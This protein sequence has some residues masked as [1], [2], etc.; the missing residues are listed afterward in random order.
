MKRLSTLGSFASVLCLAGS[1]ALAVP[2]TEAATVGTPTAQLSAISI[3]NV[4][5]T[6]AALGTL[7]SVVSQT[8]TGLTTITSPVTIQSAAVNGS[9]LSLTGTVNAIP[10]ALSGPLYQGAAPG[11]IEGSLTDA[12]GHFVI[13]RCEIVNQP[14][15]GMWLTSTAATAQVPYLGLYLEQAGTRNITFIEAPAATI[16]GTSVVNSIESTYE[17]YPVAPKADSLWLERMMLPNTVQTTSSPVSN[18]VSPAGD[19]TTSQIKTYSSTY[20]F[21]GSTF[22]DTI[23]DNIGVTY[24]PDT[25]AS[26]SALAQVR[27]T[28]THISESNGTQLDETGY[29][30]GGH[31]P[32]GVKLT[33]PDGKSQRMKSAILA[34]NGNVHGSWSVSAGYSV[35]WEGFGADI[36][37]TPGGTGTFSSGLTW[38][39][40]TGGTYLAYMKTP[41]S[42]E[43]LNTDG[44][45]LGV[46][47]Y[48]PRYNADGPAE[49]VTDRA[50][51]VY[52]LYNTLYDG[53]GYNFGTKDPYLTYTTYVE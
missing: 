25:S 49:D 15:T 37:Y 42:G 41:S 4:P 14:A 45:Y 12:T 22:T 44:Q 23:K 9:D 29:Q 20:Q 53:S 38:D 8:S 18:T 40:P 5:T 50:D 33:V 35:S 2:I 34:G 52:D 21:A 31:G 46:T 28:Y 7:S 24:P 26:G 48:D 36:S 47:F 11:T 1:I 3:A 51:F 43:Y 27:V 6:G 39:A 16:L 13:L 19:S 17:T 32:L 30:L 10:F